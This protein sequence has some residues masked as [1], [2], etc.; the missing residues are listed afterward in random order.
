MSRIYAHTICSLLTLAAFVPPRNVEKH[1]NRL[2]ELYFF[3]RKKLSPTVT[4]YELREPNE[5]QIRQ[6]VFQVLGLVEGFGNPSPPLLEVTIFACMAIFIFSFYSPT[7]FDDR[8][9]FLSQLG[10]RRGQK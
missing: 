2:Y 3:P 5:Y 10:F 4:R 9:I 7:I 1:N 8:K 6:G